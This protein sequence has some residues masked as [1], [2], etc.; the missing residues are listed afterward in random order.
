MFRLIQKH[1]HASQTIFVSNAE[2]ILYANF[3]DRTYWQARRSMRFANHLVAIAN[4]FRQSRLNSTDEEDKTVIHPDWAQMKAA[5]GSAI[6]GP[7]VAIHLRRGDFVQ[8]RPKQTPN[9]DCAVHQIR[10]VAANLLDKHVDNIYIATDEKAEQY[11]YIKH[12]LEAKGHRVHNYY[13]DNPKSASK[14]SPGEVAIIDQIIARHSEFFVGTLEST[15]SFK[16][17]EER[18][19]L[20]FEVNTTFN[21]LCAQ[22]DLHLMLKLCKQSSAWKIVY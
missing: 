9:L 12:S 20:G 19:I 22:C 8:Y 5:R 15:F 16:I 14:L 2:V 17:Q 1:F 11:E 4:N 3:G 10:F 21:A 18:E 7:Y 13:Y 6:G